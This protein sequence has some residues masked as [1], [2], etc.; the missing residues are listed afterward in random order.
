MRTDGGADMRVETGQRWQDSAESQLRLLAKEQ[1]RRIKALNALVAKLKRE[2]GVLRRRV[3][4]RAE[5]VVP[6]RQRGAG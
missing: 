4:Q 5:N 3:V 1:Q 6:L 2:N